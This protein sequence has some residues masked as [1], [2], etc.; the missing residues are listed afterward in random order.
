MNDFRGLLYTVYTDRMLQ[1]MRLPS[2][3]RN[4]G[5]VA[6][7]SLAVRALIRA[8]LAGDV[9][10]YLIK[11]GLGFRFISQLSGNPELFNLS[12][13]L[14]LN[15]FNVATATPISDSFYIYSNSGGRLR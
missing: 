3:H 15:N 9:W 2:R 11:F 14:D 10:L 1:N 7:C 8:P 6:S 5:S 12:L 4:I 13:D